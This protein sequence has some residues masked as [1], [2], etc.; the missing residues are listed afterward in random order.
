[1]K[2]V[3]Q[4]PFRIIAAYDTETTNI[5]IDNMH[6]AFPILYIIND[7]AEITVDKYV[8]GNGDNQIS[9]YRNSKGL[10]DYI[11]FA[12]ERG[13]AASYI[14]IICAYNLMFDMQTIMHDLRKKY[15]MRTTAQTSTSVY[16]LD[17]LGENDKILLRFWDTFYLEMNGLKAMGDVCGVPKAV[18]DWDYDLIR[19]PVTKLSEEERFYAGR[20]TEVIPAYLA[21]L[22]KANDWLKAEML[23]CKVLTK[24]GIVRQMAKHEIGNLRYWKANGKRA[25]LREAME[26]TCAQEKARSYQEYGLQKA[27]FRGGLTFTSANFASQAVQNVVSIDVTSMHHTFINGAYLPVHFKTAPTCILTKVAREIIETPLNDVLKYYYK[28]FRFAMHGRFVFHNL[29]LKK[30]TIF[31]RAGIA[32]IPESKFTKTYANQP[33]RDVDVRNQMAEMQIRK[34]GWGD[35]AINP[36]FAFGKLISA[37]TAYLHLSEIELWNIGQ[38]YDFDGFEVELGEYTAK[39]AVPPDY[40]SLQSNILFERKQDMKYVLS[41]YV[42]N[43]PFK[44]EIPQSIPSGLAQEIHN[45]TAT[46]S[47]LNAYY[48]ST[49]KGMFNGIYGVNAMDEHR[50]SFMIDNL[51]QIVLDE[52]TRV[53]ADNFHDLESKKSK[54]LYTYGMRIVGRSRMHL[55]IALMQLET[56]FNDKWK[57]M[58]GD[59]DSIKLALD[60]EITDGMLAKA[61]KP[62][63][64]A[65]DIAINM[66]QRRIRKKFPKLASKLTGIGHFDIEKA[67]KKN[68]TTRWQWHYEAWNKARISMINGKFHITCAGLSRPQGAYHI[69]NWCDDMYKAGYSFD[70]IASNVLGYN[71]TVDNSICHA[72]EKHQPH[73]VDIFEYDI[74]DYNDVSCSVKTYEAIGLYPV[75][76]K[77]GELSKRTPFENMQYLRKHGIKLECNE[78][79]ITKENDIIKLIELNEY[80][81]YV[82]KMVGKCNE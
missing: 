26:R 77:I 41:H 6:R 67:D 76:R 69:E 39:F 16:T 70:Q 20:D 28:P 25:T 10:L 24:T 63:G 36:V 34:D 4:K 18:G 64:I 58:G 1:M 12:I 31:E 19:T 62:I 82:V 32:I 40:V 8:I 81:D 3:E 35:R 60:D 50:E 33:G 71:V 54:V 13:T 78:R 5:E 53:N 44:L 72:L 66:T 74:T 65:S 73:V 80:G 59:T 43:Q 47:F 48:S 14:P 51:G 79:I 46:E 27:C 61:L 7:F 21:Y 49:V 37:K 57:P 17:L 45:G 75:P 22:C 55:I 42:E 2:K 38:V 23:G 15:D 30:H 68:N 9:L 56:A 29:R 11:D 52:K